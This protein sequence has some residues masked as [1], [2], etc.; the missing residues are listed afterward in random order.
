[1]CVCVCDLS[2]AVVFSLHPCPHFSWRGKVSEWQK[3]TW[4]FRESQL[5]IHNYGNFENTSEF[6]LN[7]LVRFAST[8]CATFSVNFTATTIDVDTE[9]KALKTILY[10]SNPS[11]MYKLLISVFKGF[12]F[13]ELALKFIA[14]D[15][16][17]LVK[18]WFQWKGQSFGFR[19]LLHVFMVQKRKG[20]KEI[21]KLII[22]YICVHIDH[23][24]SF[25]CIFKN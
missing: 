11:T 1:M 23:H 8:C 9:M 4:C 2:T 14:H 12:S 22:S 5:F 17:T 20:E 15:T 13:F 24:G 16:H 19:R 3:L 6:L 7:R 21:S 10:Q 18:L 25:S